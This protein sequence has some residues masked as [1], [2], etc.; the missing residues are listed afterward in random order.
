MKFNRWLLSR[1]V[2]DGK[3]V[4][5]HTWISDTHATAPYDFELNFD[6]G[7]QAFLELKSTTGPFNNRLYI[8]S[9]E[10][11]VMASEG[12]YVILARLFNLD[13]GAKIRFAFDVRERA[14]EVLDSVNFGGLDAGLVSIWADPELFDFNQEDIELI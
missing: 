10:L 3:H 13:D 5:N 14:K 4:I 1:P 11:A 2:I 8:S 7:S 6:D 12:I 9:G